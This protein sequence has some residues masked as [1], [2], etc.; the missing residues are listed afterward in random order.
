M[1]MAVKGLGELFGHGA[2]FRSSRQKVSV[3][4]T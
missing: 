4:G 1:E 3:E 2:G